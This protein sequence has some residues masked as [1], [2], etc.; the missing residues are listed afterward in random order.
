MSNKESDCISLIGM[1]T[2]TFDKHLL[3]QLS[4]QVSL[5]N[6][7]IASLQTQVNE[8]ARLIARMISVL[9]AVTSTVQMPQCV[10]YDVK[11]ILQEATQL[12]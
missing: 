4:Y 1:E 10:W 11:D 8:Q 6:Q 2:S 12:K 7:E 5:K 3:T 9:S